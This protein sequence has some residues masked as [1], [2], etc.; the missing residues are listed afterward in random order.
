VRGERERER[1]RDREGERAVIGSGEAVRASRERGR[2][3]SRL[4][5][6]A[7]DADA[8]DAFNGAE[9]DAVVPKQRVGDE[10]AHEAVREE[11]LTNA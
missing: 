3:E 9:G 4:T 7:A 6:L 2:A 11:E 10:H 5:K 8:K 1:L